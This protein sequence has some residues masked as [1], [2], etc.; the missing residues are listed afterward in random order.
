MAR[1]CGRGH[2]GKD[3]GLRVQGRGNTGKSVGVRAHGRMHW[4]ENTEAKTQEQGLL[5]K[6]QGQGAIT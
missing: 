2:R 3:M 4:G 5:G 6:G 1:V